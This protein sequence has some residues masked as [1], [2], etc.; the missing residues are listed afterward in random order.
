MCIVV[1]ELKSWKC[2]RNLNIV[3]N[4][5]VIRRVNRRRG[6]VTY[7]MTSDCDETI[8]QRNIASEDAWES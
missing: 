7:I 4:Y 1:F 8:D 5:S 6:R 2:N 3:V